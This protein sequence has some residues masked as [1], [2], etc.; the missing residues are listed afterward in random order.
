MAAVQRLSCL[1]LSAALATH[2]AV[3]AA[4][5]Y[6]AC[7]VVFNRVPPLSAKALWRM[8]RVTRPLELAWRALTAP[9]R[10]TPSVLLLGEVRCG[11]TSLASLLRS[12]LHLVGPFTPWVHPLAEDKE[13]FFF[14]G[15]YFRRVSPRLYRLCFPLRVPRWARHALPEPPIVFDGCASHFSAPWAAPLLRRALAT[16]KPLLLVC[17]REPVAQHVSWWRLEQGSMAWGDA[18]GLGSEYLGPPSRRGYPPPSFAAAVALSRSEEVCALWREAEALA[19]D[20]RP[21]RVLPEWAAPFPNG[22]LSAFDRMGRY[23][24]NIERWLAH[25]PRECFVFIH[26][27]DLA[28][29][30]YPTLDLIASKCG[31]LFGRTPA[32]QPRPPRVPSGHATPRLN[33]A[34]SLE[35]SLEPEPGKRGRWERRGCCSSESYSLS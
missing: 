35:P 23:A 26:L 6:H 3:G 19:A 29:D 12:R 32:L 20:G 8:L 11:T 30:P 21:L 10:S 13:S 25:F 15:H 27:D 28:D 4:F 14:V 31:Q 24:D 18:M 7:R 9:L 34:P 22:Q 2:L 5:A 1:G 33:A 17:I 16:P